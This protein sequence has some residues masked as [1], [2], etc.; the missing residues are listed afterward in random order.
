VEPQALNHRF[1]REFIATTSALSHVIESELRT[2]FKYAKVEGLADFLFDE[3]SGS[4]PV[5]GYL[6][7][8]GYEHGGGHFRSFVDIAAAIELMQLSTVIV[9]DVVDHTDIRNGMSAPTRFGPEVAV[10]A[11]EVLK[12]LASSL[13]LRK[14]DQQPKE[15]LEMR[16]LR[17]FEWMY[18]QICVGQIQDIVYET[19]PLISEDDYIKMVS[20]GTAGFLRGAISIGARLSHTPT[21][22]LNVLRECA[23]NLGIAFQIYDDV[24]ELSQQ[25][26][27]T[28]TFAGDI[29]RR[30]Q[31][32]PLIHLTRNSNRK[33][34]RAI[35]D[36]LGRRRIGDR[37]AKRIIK[38]MKEHGSIGY[39][40]SR[41]QQFCNKAR[42]ITRKIP[43]GVTRAR[44]LG[45]IKVIEDVDDG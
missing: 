24:Y 21:P 9:D 26:S 43:N 34:L 41:A 37:E 17:E 33:E 19:S 20:L 15:Q 35:R 40:L 39:C 14:L 3:W 6:G 5:R 32:L 22:Q 18:Q 8:V 10:L 23:W 13:F 2:A 16:A 36:L 30:K 42:A 31:R 45:V 11:G 25:C 12:S 27:P 44:L 28:K 7:R 38:G 29:K 1:E 4:A